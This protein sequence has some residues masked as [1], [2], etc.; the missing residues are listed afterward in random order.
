[1]NHNDKSRMIAKR[2]GELILKSRFK[3]T[4]RF[5]KENDVVTRQNL[6][7]FIEGNQDMCLGNVIDICEALDTNLSKVLKDIN[8]QK[9]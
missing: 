4:H 3:N 7:N 6:D 9:Q 5:C 2:I 8:S 1:M